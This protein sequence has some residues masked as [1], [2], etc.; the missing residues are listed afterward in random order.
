MSERREHIQ[1]IENSIHKLKTQKNSLPI[2][3]INEMKIW[4]LNSDISRDLWR[5]NYLKSYLK[6]E[7]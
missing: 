7:I 2:R 3:K 5:V 1:D 4:M 6:K